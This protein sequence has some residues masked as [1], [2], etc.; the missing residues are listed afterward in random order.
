ME[1]NKHV[2]SRLL[3]PSGYL[4]TVNLNQMS[5]SYYYP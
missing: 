2:Y 1:Q 4:N 3:F 5:P